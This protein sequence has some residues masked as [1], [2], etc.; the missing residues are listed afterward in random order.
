[1]SLS[2][3]H[4]YL[5]TTLTY[6]NN[7]SAQKSQRGNIRP[8]VRPN[9]GCI[10]LSGA[11]FSSW[12]FCDPVQGWKGG[13]ET[14]L[15][16]AWPLRSHHTPRFCIS[17]YHVFHSSRPTAFSSPISSGNPRLNPIRSVC[18]GGGGDGVD[19]QITWGV[20][21][22]W[23]LQSG[24]DIGLTE[25][26]LIYFTCVH[27]SSYSQHV[28]CVSDCVLTLISFKCVAI[29]FLQRHLSKCH[30]YK[31]RFSQPYSF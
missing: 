28:L 11:N 25:V 9:S 30:L 1:V 16:G 26:W 24:H 20:Q 7:A 6:S 14:R 2:I 29:S 15:L 22:Y 31:S 27:M 17:D 5:K 23:H 19:P 21:I 3:K 13:T 8:S 12:T 4:R 18:N 10:L